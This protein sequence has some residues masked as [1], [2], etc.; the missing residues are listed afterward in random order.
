MNMSDFQQEDIL[1][2]STLDDTNTETGT[3]SPTYLRWLNELHN[4]TAEEVTRLAANVESMFVIVYKCT[5]NNCS[6]KRKRR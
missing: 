1:Q 6:N 5:I 3:Q 2:H 4:M